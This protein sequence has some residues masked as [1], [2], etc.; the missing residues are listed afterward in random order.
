MI[1]GYDL[2]AFGP[3]LNGCMLMCATENNSRGQIDGLA[4]ALGEIAASRGSV[5]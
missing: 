2:A 3:S 4:S 5:K 1:G